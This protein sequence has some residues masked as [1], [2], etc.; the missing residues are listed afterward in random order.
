MFAWDNFLRG[1]KNCN[2]AKLDR[3]PIDAQGNNLLLDPC[4]DEPLDHFVWDDTTGAA[5]VVPD[6]TRAERGTTTI[7]LFQLNQEPIREER[8]VKLL[9]VLYLLAR[10]DREDP[11]EP[12]TCDRLREE[13]LPHRPWLG[14]VRQ[15][16]TRPEGKYRPLVERALA[17]LPE[18]RDKTVGGSSILKL[19]SDDADEP[20]Y[21]PSHEPDGNRDRRDDSA[22]RHSGAGRK[23]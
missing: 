8:R 3:F 5:G 9:V 15:L 19:R 22:G 18:I 13:L 1:C 21:G 16:L 4:E 12:E 7:D 17:K 2:N 10:V 20:C 23:A 6:P 14:I 11:I